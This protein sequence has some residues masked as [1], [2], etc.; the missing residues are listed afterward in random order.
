M[1]GS[2]PNIKQN[3]GAVAIGWYTHNNSTQ[4]K[5]GVSIGRD[6]G[7][8]AGNDGGIGEG[9]ILIGRSVC[10]DVSKMGSGTISIGT[11]A[12]FSNSDYRYHMDNTISIGMEA[13]AYAI[14]SENTIAIGSQAIQWGF[15]QKDA[16]A[17]GYKAGINVDQSEG[18]ILIGQDAFTSAVW[19]PPKQEA[20][21]LAIGKNI[22]SSTSGGIVQKR[23][24]LAIGTNAISN[25]TQG[26]Y[27][28]AIGA[29]AGVGGQHKNS[30]VISALGTDFTSSRE[31]GLFIKPIRADTGG[32]GKVRV[33]YN[34]ESGELF[35]TSEPPVN[36]AKDDG[37]PD[38][39]A[40]GLIVKGNVKG[41]INI[42]GQLDGTKIGR[43]GLIMTNKIGL[44]NPKVVSGGGDPNIK[45]LV[46]DI[47]SGEIKYRN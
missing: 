13:A 1:L 41:S 29:N 24:A 7:F 39:H 38:F 47:N 16:I 10:Q 43:G 21:T 19:Y 22:G 12:C 9:G 27:S 26:S 20:M 30:I 44:R 42:Y 2:S 46:I 17:I 3:T 5:N 45:G 37:S 18:A 25:G 33:M 6:A 34:Q 15:Q 14:Q 23:G 11:R 31:G 32:D 36:R 40:D 28:I 8:S 35:T 4:G